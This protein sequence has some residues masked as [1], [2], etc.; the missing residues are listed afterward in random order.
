LPGNSSD[1]DDSVISE[2]KAA[3][4][5]QKPAPNVQPSTSTQ[6]WNTPVSDAKS[7]SQGLPGEHESTLSTWQ[8]KYEVPCMDNQEAAKIPTQL[9]DM[10]AGPKVPTY[11]ES[12]DVSPIIDSQ[13]YQT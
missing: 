12:P 7:H 2:P 13:R 3:A 5:K 4:S 8:E 1:D 11:Q 9:Q 6:A 10:H